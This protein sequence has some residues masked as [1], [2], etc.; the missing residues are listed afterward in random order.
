MTAT[1]VET[2][3]S[4]EDLSELFGSENV[5]RLHGNLYRVKR[6]LINFAEGGVQ[7]EK[8]DKGKLT[9]IRFG[10]PRW[11][12]N[13]KGKPVARGLDKAK[14]E[15]LKGSIQDQGLENPLRLRLIENGNDLILQLVN[16]ERRFRSLSALVEEKAECRDPATKSLMPADELYEWVDCRI[17]RMTD[18]EAL[19]HS[20]RPN[21]TGESIGDVA[22][23]EVVKVLRSVGKGDDEILK[24]TGKSITW[25]READSLLT[26]DDKTLGA[27]QTDQINRNLALKLTEISDTNKR[28]ER[29]GQCSQKAIER[30][31]AQEAALAEAAER[32]ESEA[33]IEA[34]SAALAEAEGD[35]EAAKTHRRKASGAR[36]RAGKKAAA[37]QE[38]SSGPKTATSKDWD[39]TSDETDAAK[40]LSVAKVEKHWQVDLADIIKR[41]DDLEIDLEDARLAKLL[42]DAIVGGKREPDNKTPIAVVKILR[43]H[44]KRKASR[45]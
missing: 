30:I 6:A 5:V 24:F 20:M 25:L 33:E 41:R 9:R 21:E 16:G 7:A 8:D 15:D 23:L 31:A 14:M 28:L 12:K 27:L 35:T 26:L 36:V 37:K 43:Q 13:N 3:S 39:S 4:A 22:A 32:D 17:N 29:L 1:K 40:P 18:E 10:N 11:V 34:A 2:E 44:A 42:V 19:E 45:Q 38:L